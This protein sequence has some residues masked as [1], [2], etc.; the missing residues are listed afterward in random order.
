MT[1]PVMGQSPHDQDETLVSGLKINSIFDGRYRI[2]APIE[3]GGMGMVYRALDTSTHEQVAI[4]VL[5]PNLAADPVMRWRLEQEAYSCLYINHPNVVR[6]LDSKPNTPARPGYIVMELLQGET[7]SALLGREGRLNLERAAAL[8][9]AICDGVGA[10]HRAG[11]VH[12]DLKPSNVMVVSPD[13]RPVRG[14]ASVKVMDFGIAKLRFM[15]NGTSRTRPGEVKGTPRYMSPEQWDGREDGPR[16]DVYS[17]GVMFYEMICGAPPFNA[18][19][20]AGLERAHR[21]S[22]PQPLRVRLKLP[23]VDAVIRRALEKDPSLRQA[24]AVEFIEQLNQAVQADARHRVRCPLVIGISAA[25]AICLLA[26]WPP[27]PSWRPTVLAE[28][29]R[30]HF[31]F[32]T[33]ELG[34][35]GRE[36]KHYKGEAQFYSEKLGDGVTLDMVKVPGGP[37]MMGSPLDERGRRP[38]E[39]QKAVTVPAFYIGKFEVTQAQWRAV[40]N[41]PKVERELRAEPAGFRGDDLPINNVSWFDAVEFCARFSKMTGREYRLPTEAEWEYA[42]RAGSDKPFAFGETITKGV[43]NFHGNTAH[44][45]RREEE[46]HP[47]IMLVG[48]MGVANSFGLYD[49]HGNLQEW[50]QDEKQIKG[51]EFRALRGGGWG[52]MLDKCRCAFRDWGRPG[53]GQD[54]F[55]FRVVWVP[56]A[57]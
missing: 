7:L 37:F 9:Q 56:D 23:H 3:G 52:S 27:G 16:T 30:Q 14:G 38:D 55:G 1:N 17:L 4:K 35:S 18:S 40:A 31:Q 5:R 47:T 6:V 50:C 13:G 11:I 22:E 36:L 15:T 49:M 21:Y 46:L 12:R 2:I 42:C 20:M 57:K 33:V 54:I 51:D 48:S 39:E 43:A 24:D 41:A 10:G 28:A 45:G 44:D 8:M 26:V 25:V 19:D 32:K 34:T 29:E 53:N